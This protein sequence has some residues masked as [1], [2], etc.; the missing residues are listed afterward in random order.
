MIAK[1]LTLS[2]VSHGQRVVVRQ[3]L[4]DLDEHVRTPFRLVLTENISEKGNISPGEYRF[5]MEMIVNTERKGF[6]ANHNAAFAKSKADFFCV[7]NPDIRMAADPFPAL[8]EFMQSPAIAVVSPSILDP[9]GRVEDHA[10]HFPTVL[11]LGRKAIGMAPRE[12]IS[13]RHDVHF[14]DWISGAFMLFRA[15]AFSRV[16]GFDER[17]FLY[18]EDV[19]ICARLRDRGLEVAVCPQVSVVHA[20]QRASH[21]N[22]RYALWHT[23]SVLRFFA[24]RPAI[25]L[26]LRPRAPRI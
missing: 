24:S 1:S 18:Y 16:G 23:H 20:A 19:D 14:P 17:Y 11:E 9:T 12:S 5:P 8:L 22:L 13:G 4:A 3:L 10:R 7:L 2:V 6:G 26:G 25:A 15:E 21:R